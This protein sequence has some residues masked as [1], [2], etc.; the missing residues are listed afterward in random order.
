VLDLT[1]DKL[2]HRGQT[3]PS[4]TECLG[5]PLEAG[6]VREAEAPGV[7]MSLSF[8]QGFALASENCWPTVFLI[9]AQCVEKGLPPAK[10]PRRGVILR[11]GSVAGFGALAVKD[12]GG[13]LRA[14]SRLLKS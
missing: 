12:R 4:E 3:G 7:V 2:I 14:E 5:T 8:R 10:Q 6:S 11:N 9:P 13:L 1:I